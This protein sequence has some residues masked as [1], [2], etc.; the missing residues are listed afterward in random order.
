MIKPRST[1]LM[2]Q[3]ATVLAA[4]MIAM[5]GCSS[6]A[7]GIPPTATPKKTTILPTLPTLPTTSPEVPPGSPTLIYFNGII[8]TMD[9]DYPQAQ[10]I[11]L[12]EDKILALGSN[13]D[14]LAL[15]V[16]GTRTIDLQGSTLMPGFVDTHSH[17]FNSA[18]NNPA[19]GNLEKAQELALQNGITTFGSMYTTTGFLEEIRSFDE[20]GQLLVRTSLYM[21]YVN[22]CGV[23]ESDWFRRYPATHQ[24]GETLRIAGVKIFTDGGSCGYP[25]LSFERATGGMGDLW[26]NQ[27]ELDTIVSDIHQAGYQVAIH[28]IGDRAVDQALNAIEFTLDGKPNTLRH[29]IEH[30]ATVRPD[31]YPR[32][33]DI[34]VVASLWGNIWSCKDVFH[35]VG[36]VPDPPENQ[37]WNFPYR[38]MWDASPEAHFAWQTDYPW[39]SINPL[40]HMYSLVTPQDIGGDASECP[41]PAWFGNRTLTLEEALPMMTI[42]GAY[43]LFREQ[44]VGSLVPGKYADLII[45]SGNPAADLD[46]IRDL[47][48]WMTMISGQ[49]GWC[50]AGHEDLCPTELPTSKSTLPPTETSMIKAGVKK[51]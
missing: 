13:D 42:E 31:S 43:A 6:T 37:A 51:N 16:P 35:N 30:N 15:Q 4:L 3:M 46:A 2:M 12:A 17:L 45:L 48:V 44:E 11:A 19:T 33:Q 1:R 28:A 14:I 10:A 34:G 26:F 49:V 25:A 9:D 8:L 5:S 21:V 38:A 41:D 20:S 24:P 18:R 47:K 22:A 39:N 50:A 40:F 32:Y 23:V 36:I 27:E 29:R 7:A